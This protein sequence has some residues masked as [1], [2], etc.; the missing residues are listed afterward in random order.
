MTFPW[1][2]FRIGGVLTGERGGVRREGRGRGGI[3]LLL[4]FA[5]SLEFAIV[6]GSGDVDVNVEVL[7]DVM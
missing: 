3:S 5:K 7:C 4:V 1:W 6:V 2:T